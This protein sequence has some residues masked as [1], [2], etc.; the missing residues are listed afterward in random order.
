MGSGVELNRFKFKYNFNSN[1]C[2]TLIAR[3]LYD[4]GILEFV[5]AAKIIRRKNKEIKFL[6]VGGVDIENPA[7][8]KKSQIEQW[9]KE[10][11]IEWLGHVDNIEDI[12]KKTRIFCLPSYREGMPKSIMEASTAG[13]PV[14]TADTVGC[15]DSIIPGVTGEL[16]KDKD[17]IE[18]ANL[19]LN[20]YYNEKK[21]LKYS[22]NSIK[23]ARD[24]FDIK[25]VISKTQS[26]YKKLANEI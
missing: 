23:F 2:V 1:V 4:K 26:L 6:L 17:H 21:L 9:K 5:K 11:G 12:L 20:L 15:R 24:N 10:I 18:L 25:I 22:K 13:I 8:I 19:I 14:I 3:M 7:K 16:V